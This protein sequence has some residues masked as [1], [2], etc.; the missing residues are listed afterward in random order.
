[1]MSHYC[2]HLF[3]GLYLQLLGGIVVVFEPVVGSSASGDVQHSDF[4]LVQ[5]LIGHTQVPDQMPNALIAT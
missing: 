5:R 3:V 1:M 2:L 4:Q